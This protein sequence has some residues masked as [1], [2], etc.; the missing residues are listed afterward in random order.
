MQDAFADVACRCKQR[1]LH[2]VKGSK[3]TKFQFQLL[4]VTSWRLMYA[5]RLSNSYREVLSGAPCTGRT[6][7]FLGNAPKMGEN[8]FHSPWGCCTTCLTFLPKCLSAPVS[9]RGWCGRDISCRI[10]RPVSPSLCEICSPAAA[11]GCGNCGTETC[12]GYWGWKPQIHFLF[13]DLILGLIWNG[14]TGE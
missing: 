13:W 5:Q 6:S 14:K 3:R 9:G 10:P 2:W 8:K 7:T 1:R 12:A 11:A 4:L